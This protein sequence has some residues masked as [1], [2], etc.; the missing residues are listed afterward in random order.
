MSNWQRLATKIVYQNA[1]IT[2]HE[3]SVVNPLGKPT[4]YS[5]VDRPP[6]VFIVAT[7]DD[8]KVV[9]VKQ[10]RYTTG[11]PTWEV[12]AGGT[13]GEDPMVA[14]KR[15][16]EEEAGMHADKWV[17]LA[18]ESYPW[19]AFSP[20]RN[21]TF[22]ADGLHK[23]KKP[24]QGDDLMLEVKSFTWDELKEMVKNAEITDGQTITS[25][26]RAGLH[27]GKLR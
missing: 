13:E 15:E 25:L 23:A 14:A 27:L 21:I 7:D 18:G 8:G 4:L 9:L 17:Q 22:V 20:E 1:Y 2:V 12:P 26:M 5:W 6:A 19:N 10:V 16:L 24:A 3:D 11:Q